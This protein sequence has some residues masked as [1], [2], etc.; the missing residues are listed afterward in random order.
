M[1]TNIKSISDIISEKM[2]EFSAIHPGISTSPATRIWRAAT[3]LNRNVEKC[4][5]IILDCKEINGTSEIAQGAKIKVPS[6]FPKPKPQIW[7]SL[8]SK[9]FLEVS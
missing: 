1:R 3:T 4:S 8:G 6:C 5:A 7:T 2:Q 9:L